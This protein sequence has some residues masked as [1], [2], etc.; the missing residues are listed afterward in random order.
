MKQYNNQKD[1]HKASLSEIIIGISIS[2]VAFFQV[3]IWQGIKSLLARAIEK[4]ETTTIIQQTHHYF[5]HHRAVNGVLDTPF[6][7][8]EKKN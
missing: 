6:L 1:T 3:K 7:Y 8:G 4:P 5:H 2:I